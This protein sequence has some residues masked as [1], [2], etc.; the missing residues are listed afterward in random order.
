MALPSSSGYAHGCDS[1]LIWINRSLACR[2]RTWF[3][4]IKT[5]HT[6]TGAAFRLSWLKRGTRGAGALQRGTNRT[7]STVRWVSNSLTQRRHIERRSFI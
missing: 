4:P 3:G 6:K 7:C 5:R 1:S 2:G